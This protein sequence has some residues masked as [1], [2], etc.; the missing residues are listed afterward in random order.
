MTGYRVG[1]AIGPEEVVASMV[2]MQENVCACAPL[3]SQY[4]AIEAYTNCLDQKYILDTFEQRRNVIVEGINN[5]DGLHCNKPAGTFYLFVNISSTGLDCIDFAYK[6][7]ED[8]K[9][10]VVPAV[11]YGEAYKDYIRI[12]FTL[13]E[14]KLMKA[15]DRIRKFVISR[16]TERSDKD[17]K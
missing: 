14:E 11:T 6:L 3:P 12:A 8:Q 7:L 9:V 1:F 5:I 13:E 2:K 4:A 16:N 17:A 10:A 15:V